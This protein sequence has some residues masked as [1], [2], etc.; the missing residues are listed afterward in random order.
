MREVKKYKVE[1]GEILKREVS[2]LAKNADEALQ[3]VKYQHKAELL[4]L[5]DS[6]YVGVE[7]KVLEEF[8]K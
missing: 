6:D 4:V 7:I 3:I 8:E 2:V 1:V 5:D